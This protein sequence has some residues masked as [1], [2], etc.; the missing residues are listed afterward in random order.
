MPNRVRS[1]LLALCAAFVLLLGVASPGTATTR[2]LGR[3]LVIR[4][5]TDLERHDVGAL[6]AF[7]SPAFQI[8]RADGSRLGKSAY[9]K[10]LPTIISFKLR[11]LVATAK[12]DELV[13]TYEVAA[14]E[15]VN[16][17]QLHAGYAP[18]LS[19]FVKADKRWQLLAH[20]NFNAPK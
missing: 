5:F 4:Y 3:S 1:L 15:I 12:G 2:S 20:A 6:R 7:I 8:Q 16:G 13:T 17:K 14:D 10:H 19:V 11:G 18:R 9:L